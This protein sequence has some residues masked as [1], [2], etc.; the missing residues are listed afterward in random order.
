[1]K[2]IW[3]KSLALILLLVFVLAPVSLAVTPH[4]PAEA[5]HLSFGRDKKFT[6]MQISDIQ[7][8]PGLMPAAARFLKKALKDVNPD[9]VVLT[10]DN[11]FGGKSQTDKLTAYSIDGFMRIFE[12]AGIPVAA[13]FGNHDDEGNTPKEAQM[14]MYMK[15]N[16][17]IGHDEGPELSGVGNYNVP[18]YSST[19]P[20]KM[21]Y[22]LWMIDSGTYD[23]V[24]GGYAHV[25]QDQLDWYVDTSNDLKAANGGTP[26]PAMMFQ[27]IVI[28]EVYEAFLEVPFGTPGAIARYS[29]YF[30][31]NPEMTRSGV[32]TEGAY[33][34][35][36]N[37]GQFDAIKMQNDVVAL[38]VGHDHANSYQVTVRG[39]DIVCTPTAGI[40]PYGDDNRGVRVIT[41][42]END[43]TD[44]D[45]Y[46]IHYTDYFVKDSILNFGYIFMDTAWRIIYPF[47]K[48]VYFIENIFTRT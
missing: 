29:K 42:D 34:P 12:S 38:F 21:A 15:Y 40:A 3:K 5:A 9:L 16:C 35:D 48:L 33:P 36:I 43:L 18:I 8:G 4:T 26:V 30:I 13:V 45:N 28:P 24:N 1:M 47:Q 2:N 37:G 25:Q 20:Q 6:I 32:L 39:V 17:F 23:E 31:L 27:H 11:I 7:D 46:L 44:Y 41:L 22:N 10:G 19:N 14:A